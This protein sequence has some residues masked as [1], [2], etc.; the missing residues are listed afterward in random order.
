MQRSVLIPI[1]LAAVMTVGSGKLA[2]AQAELDENRQ[3]VE[4]DVKP[5]AMTEQIYKRLSAI[6]ELMGEGQ[7]AEAMERG[8]ALLKKSMNDYERALVL[9]AIGFIHANE[10]RIPQAIDYFEQSLA[11]NS[12]QTAAQQGMLYSLASLYAAESQFL[13][14][15]ETAREWFKYE[16]DPKAD[17]YMLIGSAFSQL[18]RYEDA[19]PYVIR[20]IEVSAKPTESWYQLLL[21]IHFETGQIPKAVPLLQQMVELWPDKERYWETLSGAHMELNQDRPALSTMMVAYR[22]GMITEEEK[23]LSLVRLN[24]FLDIPFT[25]GQILSEGMSAGQIERNK[26][27][28]TLLEQ[29]WTAAQEYDKALLVMS[30]LGELTGDP[31]YSIR[32]AK[33]YNELTRWEEVVASANRALERGY[34]DAGEAYL[35]IGTAY[36]EMGRL[37]DS[38]AAFKQAEDSGT[39]DQRRNARAWIGFVNDR[40]KIAS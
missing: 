11:L 6:H 20:A 15:I 22:K 12:L 14:S 1:L 33:I 16:Q 36:S 28:L 23:L 18:E 30:E 37:R 3:V 29:A 7:N 34:E 4:R 19:R 13:K 25:A 26:K 39:A 17:A 9:Q 21:A 10:N 38:L 24:M 31:E 27:S 35:L 32:Q 2:Y 8:Q 40:L 5:Q